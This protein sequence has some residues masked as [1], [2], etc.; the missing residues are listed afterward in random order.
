MALRGDVTDSGP[1][2]DSDGAPAES[3]L[4][5]PPNVPRVRSVCE[6]SCGGIW[7]VSSLSS[8]G[9]IAS[10]QTWSVPEVSLSLDALAALA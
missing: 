7:I 5:L 3:H 9:S 10:A 8:R 2:D 6:P 1:R 4:C